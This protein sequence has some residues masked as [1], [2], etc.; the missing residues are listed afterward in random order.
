MQYRSIAGQ[1][2]LLALA[3]QLTLLV[4]SSAQTAD[5]SPIQSRSARQLNY[6]V[7]LKE[8]KAN[9]SSQ[10]NGTRWLVSSYSRQ[11]TSSASSASSSTKPSGLPSCNTGQLLLS[12]WL[13]RLA[14]QLKPLNFPHAIPVNCW[15]TVIA[16]ASSSAN[17]A[18][19]SSASSSAK[20]SGLPSCNPSQ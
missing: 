5:T 19:A 15:T 17:I 9:I 6:S 18:S 16:S 10:L 12:C 8:F 13:A 7:E 2:L 4:S 11:L 14:H 20:V 1:L 3:R